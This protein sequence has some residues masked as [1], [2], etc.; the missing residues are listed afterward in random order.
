[1][2]N[3]LNAFRKTRTDAISS[4]NTLQT[5]ETPITTTVINLSPSNLTSPVLVT[6]TNQSGPHISSLNGSLSFNSSFSPQISRRPLGFAVDDQI[7]IDFGSLYLK[8]GFSGESKPRACN[9]H[10]V[11]IMSVLPEGGRVGVEVRA[12]Y[13]LNFKNLEF[14]ESRLLETFRVMY[15]NILA[16][17]PK[18]RKVIIC[19][20]ILLPYSIKQLLCKI[21]FNLQVPSISF[22]PSHLLA[23]FATGNS[24]GLV[25]DCGYH[26][27]VIVPIYDGRPLI[28]QLRTIPV[29]G[30]SLNNRLKLLLQNHGVLIANNELRLPVPPNYLDNLQPEF[31][32]NLKTQICYIAAPPTDNLV[33]E[34]T[35]AYT[36]YTSYALPIQVVVENNFKLEIPGWIRERAAEILFE[37]DWDDRTIANVIL[38]S[39]LK[40]PSDIRTELTH[41]IM[42]IGGNSMLPGFQNRM[43]EEILRAIENSKRGTTIK[44]DHKD[45]KARE[46]PSVKLLHDLRSNSPF[47]ESYSAKYMEE[48][49]NNAGSRLDEL[50]SSSGSRL[51]ELR[52]NSGSR[53][54]ELRKPPSSPPPKR[55]KSMKSASS[56]SLKRL[57]SMIMIQENKDILE[58]QEKYEKLKR[59]AGKMK[60][61]NYVFAQNC[62]SWVGGKS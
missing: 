35:D 60:I 34:E 17:D 28:P 4:Q 18:Q 9:P 51:D 49:R 37:G 62:V 5:P 50:R 36:I 33:E 8:C 55:G 1:M 52:S 20:N 13:D 6:R 3:F 31:I 46:S 12:L 26:E 40:C 57:S 22:I 24:T 14:V 59:L 47:P 23:L 53:L 56:Q 2:S 25:V 19:E 16:A 61:L 43:E 44:G 27:T 38:E 54:D 41:N 10:S 39:I 29:G 42:F 45:N 48:F 32:E 21:L 30:R 7:V 15:N 11:P 58:D